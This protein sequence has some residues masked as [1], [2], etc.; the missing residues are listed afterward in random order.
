MKGT[1]G[2]K[3]ASELGIVMV[4]PDTSAR[5][6]GIDGEKDSWDFGEGAGFYIDAT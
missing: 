2:F 1:I 3:R 5:G 6:A 4:F